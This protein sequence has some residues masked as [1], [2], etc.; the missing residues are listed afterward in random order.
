MPLDRS[1]LIPP[2]RNVATR[3]RIDAVRATSEAG[4]GHP[5]SCCSAADLVAALFFA[6]MRFDPKD[7]QHPG[8]DRFVLSKG[9][10]APLLY[11]AWSAAGAFP[12]EHLL[13]LR[14]FTSDLEG[15]P[16]PR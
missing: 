6:E 5:T 15:H 3:L 12:R 11:A 13:T 10:A 2:L 8:S 16:M 7:P 9:H 4:S 1:A 14:Q